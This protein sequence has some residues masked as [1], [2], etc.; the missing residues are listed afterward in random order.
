[1]KKPQTHAKLVELGRVE[2]SP[3]FFLRDFLY[4]EIAAMHGLANVPDDPDLAIA[5]GTRLC[6]ELLEPLQATF[7]RLH[8]VSGYRSAEVNALGHAK[9]Y[10]C[11]SNER[12]AAGHIWDQRDARGQMGATAGIVVPSL[13]GLDDWRGLAWWMHDHLPYGSIEFFPGRWAFN[14]QWHEKPLRMIYSHVPDA[15]GYLTKP[16]MAGHD[17]DHRA[18]WQGIVPSRK[19]GAT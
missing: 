9:G 2:L 8:I 1:M 11:A 10:G 17:D 12:S 3:S 13:S 15:R 4:S 6:A 18:A 19:G 14:L 16:G 5:A 7:G